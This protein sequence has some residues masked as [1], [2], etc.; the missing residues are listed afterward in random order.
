MGL[1]KLRW[2]RGIRGQER[3]QRMAEKKK[4]LQSDA[5]KKRKI[6]AAVNRVK[7]RDAGSSEPD[8]PADSSSTK[9]LQ[10]KS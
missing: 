3:R 1:F 9:G 5:E 6:A 7:A 4:A 2:D 8:Q 10:D